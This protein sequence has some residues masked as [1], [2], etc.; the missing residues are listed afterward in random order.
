MLTNNC[1]FCSNGSLV[2][3][4][5]R[6][7]EE[8]YCSNCL[9]VIKSASLRFSYNAVEIAGEVNECSEGGLPGFKGSGKK[10]K[11]HVYEPG[12]ESGKERAQQKARQSSYTTMK[13]SHIENLI[14]EGAFGG[15]DTTGVEEV[16][17]TNG[18][19]HS[20][21]FGPSEEIPTDAAFGTT[22]SKDGVWKQGPTDI[23]NDSVDSA[24]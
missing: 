11:C 14:R 3:T 16:A 6:A 1:P 9:R 2:R 5:S 19:N 17:T 18:E 12:D 7:G 8:I 21:H 10:A 4:A 22:V 24:Y 20:Q 23:N 13:R 15:F